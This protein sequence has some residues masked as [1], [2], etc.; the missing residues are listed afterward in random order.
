MARFAYIRFRKSLRFRW[1]DSPWWGRCNWRV[2]CSRTAS[3]VTAAGTRWRPSSSDEAPSRGDRSELEL[4]MD[5]P[6]RRPSVKMLSNRYAILSHTRTLTTA[7]RSWTF[8][9]VCFTIKSVG[10]SWRRNP[11]Y[12]ITVTIDPWQGRSLSSRNA[13]VIVCTLIPTYWLENWRL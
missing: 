2:V 1:L 5:S 8:K 11:G 3:R 6:F 9:H 12:R 13:P 7:V 10:G 4:W